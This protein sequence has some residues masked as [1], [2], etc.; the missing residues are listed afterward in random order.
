MYITPA[1]LAAG[2][3]VLRELTQIFELADEQLLSLTIAGGDRSAYTAEQIAAADAALSEIDASITRADGEI[4]T[5]LV[6]RG[7][8]VPVSAVQFPVL[9]TWARMIARYHLQPQRDRSSEETGRVERDY[10]PALAA[11]AQ[12]ADGKRSLGA[13]DP[14]AQAVTA[15]GAEVTSAERIF[16]RKT[17]QGL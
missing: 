15:G 7:Y 6:Q 8:T 12:V 17:M 16:T 10:R 9:T 2:A 5:Y 14:L 11:L 3:G 4:D 1:Q 13:D